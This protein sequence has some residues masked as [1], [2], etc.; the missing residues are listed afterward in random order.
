MTRR[1]LIIMITALTLLVGIAVLVFVNINKPSV[2]TLTKDDNL[3]SMIES[4][5]NQPLYKATNLKLVKKIQYLNQW[6]IADIEVKS[7]PTGSDGKNLRFVYE[8]VDGKI[9][10]IAYSGDG[11]SA[12]AFPPEAPDGLVERANQPL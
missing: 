9:K 8:I 1:A 5:T 2:E 4:Q 12:N 6:Y 11:F 3:L 10:V 7:E